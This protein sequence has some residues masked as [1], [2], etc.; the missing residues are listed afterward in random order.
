MT[1]ISHPVGVG[2]WGLGRHACRKILPAL[3][4]CPNTILVGVTT[5]DHAVALEE[6]RRYSC[7]S[8][9]SPAAMLSD[10]DVD[11]VYVTTPTGLHHTHGME[12]LK[13]GKHLWSEKALTDSLPQAQ[14]LVRESYERDLGLCEGLMYLYHPQF[15][16]I[17]DAVT[18]PSFGRILS[19]NCQFGLPPLGEP[20][21]RF[22]R[23]LGGG[24][25]LDVA[26]YPVS[27]THR[28]LGTD[29]ELVNSVLFEP[30]GFGVDTHGFALL[31]REDGAYA[32][33]EWG[34][35]RAYKNE[36]SV[37]GEN[38]SLHSDFI[39]SK[40]PDYEPRVSVRDQH[41]KVRHADIEPTNSF[42]SMFST[43]ARAVYDRESRDQLREEAELQARCLESLRLES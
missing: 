20:G 42:C 5:R 34:Y 32:F 19:I 28:L 7:R 39:F 31:S 33:L 30:S 6:S 37:W 13:A 4:V 11:A 15:S 21:F 38:A 40:P 14:E 27:A 9:S 18:K 3:A 12:V 41:G 26:P 10:E 23:E 22:D 35:N 24:A 2:V 43:F 25:L 29:L 8:W 17:V 16:F 36:I 1:E